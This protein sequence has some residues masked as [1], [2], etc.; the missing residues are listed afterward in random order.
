MAH[1]LYFCKIV[2]GFLDKTRFNVT[3]LQLLDALTVAL[4]ESD[5]KTAKISLSVRIYMKIRELKD[6]TETRKQ[7]IKDLDIIANFRALQKKGSFYIDRIIEKYDIGR[8]VINVRFSDD[9]Y[10]ALIQSP[11]VPYPSLLFRMNGKY[12]PNSF[13]FLRRIVEH[14]NMN[15]GKKNEDIISVKTLLTATPNLPSY[16]K[17]MATGGHVKKK[18]IEPFARDMNAL[19]EVI[20]WEYCHSNGKPLRE[21]EKELAQTKGVEFYRSLFA[22]CFVKTTHKERIDSE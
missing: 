12:N 5:A 10:N 13:Y 8:G 19:S 4:T 17:V 6:Y 14:K 2:P 18:I 7:M 1:E 16:E 3:T 9:F 22:N 20:S 15:A 21:Y 11:E